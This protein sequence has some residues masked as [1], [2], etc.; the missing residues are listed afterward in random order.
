MQKCGTVWI[1]RAAPHHG[2]IH[3]A[4]LKSAKQA[5]YQ[6]IAGADVNDEELV[7]EI[8]ISEGLLNSQLLTYMSSDVCDFLPLTLNDSS[9]RLQGQESDLSL[10]D[11]LQC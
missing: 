5:T 4:L 1:F 3:E 6:I 11:G 2:G 9:Y 10:I 8:V 7:T